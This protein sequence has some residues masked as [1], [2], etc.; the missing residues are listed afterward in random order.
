[1]DT[2]DAAVLH[3]EVAAVQ[4]V[5]ISVLRKLTA[6]RPDLEGRLREAFDEAEIILAGLAV[7]LGEQPT[8]ITTLNALRVVEEIRLGVLRDRT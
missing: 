1:M 2:S 7:N 4:A 3:A 8:S 5:L 6:Q